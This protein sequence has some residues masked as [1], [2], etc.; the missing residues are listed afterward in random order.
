M[1]KSY[2]LQKL[3]IRWRHW[4]THHFLENWTKDR[5][6]YALQLQGKGTD[7][8]DQRIAEDII[9]FIISSLTLSIGFL[10]QAVMLISFLGVLW[11]LS[12]TLHIPLGSYIVSIPGYMCWG[13]LLYA[14]GGTFF[15]FT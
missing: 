13:A 14:I 5:R 7:N 12:G 3:E 1:L 15:L 11:G 9:Q 6:Y 2:L 8:P 10:Q 4:L